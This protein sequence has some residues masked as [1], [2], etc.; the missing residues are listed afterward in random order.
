MYPQKHKFVIK[1]LQALTF[2]R[3]EGFP[4]KHIR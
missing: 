4:G 1:T 2:Q 3:C